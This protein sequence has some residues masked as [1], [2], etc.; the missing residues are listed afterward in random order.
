MM[1][2]WVL[3]IC[4]CNWVQGRGIRDEEEEER[5]RR[6][7]QESSEHPCLSLEHAQI[8]S[9]TT[10][11]PQPR[12]SRTREANQPTKGEQ[13]QGPEEEEEEIFPVALKSFLQSLFEVC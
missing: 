13:D 6:K 12:E 4:G 7:G 8:H 1:G 3:D 10:T 2:G 5:E 11:R 9:S